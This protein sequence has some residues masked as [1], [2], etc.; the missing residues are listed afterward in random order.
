MNEYI[1]EI[2]EIYSRIKDEIQSRLD[3]FKQIRRVG[4]DE[5]IFAELVFCILTPQSRAKSC[6]KAVKSLIEKNLLFNGNKDRI[7][8]ELYGV[9]FQNNKAKYIVEARAQLK[10]FTKVLSPIQLWICKVSINKKREWLVKNIKGFGYKEASHFIRNIGLGEDIAI[11]DRHILKNMKLLNIIDEIPKVLS[12]KKYL[13]IE[14]KIR[15]FSK[16][17][18][19]PLSHL[20]LV[21]WYKE[22][23][24]VF[25]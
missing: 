8:K 13:E 22:V 18:N 23:G 1:V 16:D 7:A 24:E 20:D 5:D 14:E 25:K 21:F 4:N 11:L 19:I 2:K 17:I 12:K 9:R 10:N 6:W 3:E 15:K